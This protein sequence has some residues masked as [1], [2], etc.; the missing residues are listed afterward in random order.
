ME[1]AF[2]R[3]EEH[4]QERKNISDDLLFADCNDRIVNGVLIVHS[5]ILGNCANFTIT[6]LLV[7]HRAIDVL[8]TLILNEEGLSRQSR[9]TF[10]GH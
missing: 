1:S 10:E 3:K 2:P 9:V 7:L 8:A 6:A 5:F 4:F